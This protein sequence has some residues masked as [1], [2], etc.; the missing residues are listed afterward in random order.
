M[1]RIPSR[2]LVLHDVWITDVDRK[3]RSESIGNSNPMCPVL[4]REEQNSRMTIVIAGKGSAHPIVA[5]Q[6]IGQVHYSGFSGR[7]VPMKVVA[8][9]SRSGSKI[10]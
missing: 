1:S 2:L 6:C 7:Q 10:L 4:G 9:S 3:E 5:Q 8:A